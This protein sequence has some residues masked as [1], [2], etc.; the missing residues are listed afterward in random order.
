MVAEKR[1]MNS[2]RKR[3]VRNVAFLSLG[4]VLFFAVQYVLSFKWFYP[5]DPEGAWAIFQEFYDIAEKSDIKALFLGTSHVYNGVNPMEIYKE[6]GIAVYDLSTSSQPIEASRYILEDALERTKLEY[7]FLDASSLFVNSD[8]RAWY[9]YVVDNMKFSIS[10]IRLA[11]A[12]AERFGEKRKLAAFLGVFFP[13]Y[14][15][16]NRWTE[17]ADYDFNIEGKYNMLWKGYHCV[18]QVQAANLKVASMNYDADLLETRKNYLYRYEKGKVSVKEY[19]KTLKKVAVKKDKL[20]QLLAIRELCDQAGV[21]LCLFKVPS[22]QFVQYYNGAWTKQ[23]SETIKELSEK[24]DIP[25]LDLMYDVDLSIDWSWDTCDGGKHM[26][27]T[28]AEKVSR[29]LADYLREELQL[30]AAHNPS[31]E[32]DLPS[33][34]AIVDI[35]SIQKIRTLKKYLNALSRMDNITIFISASQDLTNSLKEEDKKALNR[36]G[37]MKRGYDLHF[38]DSYLAIIDNGKMVHEAASDMLL[39][40]EGR[41]DADLQY[42]LVSGGW[43]AGSGSSILLNDVEYSV[44]GR[45]LNIVVYD[46]QFQTVIDSVRFDTWQTGNQLAIRDNKRNFVRGYS[47]WRLREDYKNGLR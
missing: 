19:D 39:K 4:L 2:S 12:Y 6:S 20:T 26:N 30:T 24:Y 43:Y 42:S 10:K 40:K 46:K 17:L 31:Y 3:F 28:G 35:L 13:I 41:M 9:R 22:L 23:K 15:Y 34:N 29:Y 36:L 27:S 14:E 8:D 37:L 33:Y 47:N 1:D 21:K 18:S 38:G 25:F 5:N 7:V 45:G 16:H 44:Q 11:A 32:E